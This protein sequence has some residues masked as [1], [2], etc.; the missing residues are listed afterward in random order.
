MSTFS[1]NFYTVDLAPFKPSMKKYD[2]HVLLLFYSFILMT[3][4]Q[5]L[6]DQN[7]GG[8]F[9][10][11]LTDE[12]LWVHVP[13]IGLEYGTSSDAEILILINFLKNLSCQLPNF[14]KRYTSL[15]FSGI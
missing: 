11:G 4:H 3:N 14:K 5:K 13:E 12:L 15:L 9:G 10:L 6:S 1:K 7:M 8:G 2:A